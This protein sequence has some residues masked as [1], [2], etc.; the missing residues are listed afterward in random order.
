M[1]QREW[2]RCALFLPFIP[3]S[4]RPEHTR[5]HRYGK[6]HGPP[7]WNW[8]VDHLGS[9]IEYREAGRLKRDPET[10]A[11]MEA[12][13]ERVRNKAREMGV[14]LT[15]WELNDLAR[16]RELEIQENGRLSLMKRQLEEK[17]MARIRAEQQKEDEFERQGKD[18]FL[19]GVTDP[20]KRRVMER[21]RRS[22]LE[23]ERSEEDGN[24]EGGALGD[25]E[26]K[27]GNGAAAVV[28]TSPF[29]TKNEMLL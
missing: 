4:L 25:G 17:K 16:L 14:N 12:W 10:A 9:K 23:I 2:M 21:I 27:T 13:D 1:T 5:P 26:Y 24:I 29:K 20:Q 8:G 7:E 15:E 28:S 19:E 11:A 22:I 3:N 6:Q 18:M